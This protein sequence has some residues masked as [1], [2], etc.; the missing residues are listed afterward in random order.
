M[1]AWGGLLAPS[2]GKLLMVAFILCTTWR[3]DVSSSA[4][5]SSQSRPQD[6]PEVRCS[7]GCPWTKHIFWTLATWMFQVL[8][9]NGHQPPRDFCG[10]TLGARHWAYSDTLVYVLCRVAPDAEAQCL[11]RSLELRCMNGLSCC[12]TVGSGCTPPCHL[13][14]SYSACPQTCVL[15]FDLQLWTLSV[16][17]CVHCT[18]V[19]AISVI[20]HGK[21]SLC[22]H[23]PKSICK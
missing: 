4:L 19:E 18:H 2:P 5:S 6:S 13:W 14:D 8:Q 12:Y 17:S 21:H 15:T 22:F 7:W 20:C 10:F 16:V 3:K 23:L 11:L 1:A 9:G